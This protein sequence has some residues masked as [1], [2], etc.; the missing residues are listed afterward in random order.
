MIDLE[1]MIVISVEE[2]KLR[3]I[4]NDYKIAEY[5]ISTSKFGIG[6]KTGSNMT[7][8]GHHIVKEKIGDHVPANSIYKAGEFTKEIA[9]IN[10]KKAVVEDLV[11][12]RIVKLEGMENGINRGSGIDSYKREIWIHGTPAEDKIGSP[13]SHGCIRMKNDDIILLFNSIEVGTPV[14]I[15]MKLIAKVQGRKTQFAD[16]GHT[17]RLK[18][19]RKQ[20]VLDSALYNLSGKDRRKLEERGKDK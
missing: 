6:N 1:K 9:T 4:Q 15:E 14:N 19:R 18:D 8:S 20:S 2:Q 13:V 7:P 11:T 3:L 5:S 10:N 12:T 17:F 16:R